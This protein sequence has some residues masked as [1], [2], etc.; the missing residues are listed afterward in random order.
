MEKKIKRKG[1]TSSTVM[2]CNQLSNIVKLEITK[3]I[4]ALIVL[5]VKML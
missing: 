4:A 3:F 5:I 2:G 1:K